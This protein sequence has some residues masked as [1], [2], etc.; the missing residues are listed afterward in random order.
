MAAAASGPSSSR[1]EYWWAVGNLA[2]PENFT[3]G[4]FGIQPRW[5]TV[6]SQFSAHW[7]HISH[8][9][10][11]VTNGGIPQSGNLSLH[12]DMWSR[13]VNNERHGGPSKCTN[14]P[15]GFWDCVPPGFDGN[16]VIDFEEWSSVYEELHPR[17]QNAS[18]KLVRE[19]HSDWTS[20]QVAT[21]AKAQFEAAAVK[22][23]IATVKRG[24]ELRPQ[25]RWGWYGVPCAPAAC[26]GAV[27]C[28]NSSSGGPPE[29]GFADPVQGKRFRALDTVVQPVA[30]ASDALFPRIYISPNGDDCVGG[31]T[32]ATMTSWIQALVA[33][34]SRLMRHRPNSV[35]PFMWQFYSG[36]NDQNKRP[37]SDTDR[38]IAMTAP[39]EC[40]LCKCREP[41]L[42]GP[43]AISSSL[44]KYTVHLSFGGITRPTIW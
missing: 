25:C 21:A 2:I 1:F 14:M 30:D 12:L 43:V 32:A 27:K 10:T 40:C 41:S 37:L 36:P 44:H 23:L 29:C 39:C 16:C 17:Y 6:S 38:R 26:L 42:L 4:Q 19:Q 20:A 35:V 5:R 28:I 3:H 33:E 31:C 11:Q 7:P 13:A 8:D 34:A 22:F 15:G 9:G 18:L 24:K